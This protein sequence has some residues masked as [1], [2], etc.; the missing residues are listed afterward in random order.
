MPF[1]CD[2]GCDHDACNLSDECADPQCDGNHSTEDDPRYDDGSHP[3]ML[4]L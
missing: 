3:P 4:P 1:Y 2:H